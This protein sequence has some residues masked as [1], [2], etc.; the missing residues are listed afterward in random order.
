MVGQRRKIPLT[1]PGHTPPTLTELRNEHVQ[2][3]FTDGVRAAFAK[4]LRRKGEG[5]IAISKAVGGGASTVHRIMKQGVA[6]AA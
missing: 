3:G 4:E 6:E 2:G 5:M 1:L